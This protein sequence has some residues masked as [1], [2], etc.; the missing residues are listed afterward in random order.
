MSYFGGGRVLGA[1]TREGDTMCKYVHLPE[2]KGRYYESKEIRRTGKQ[3]DPGLSL[4]PPIHIIYI[5]T[6]ASH[7]EY[8]LKPLC[9]YY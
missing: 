9:F 8:V 3:G 6:Q 7:E 4:S 5:H 2:E 1:M